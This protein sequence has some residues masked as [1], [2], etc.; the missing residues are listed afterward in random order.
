MELDT[1]GGRWFV[2]QQPDIA[3]A[4]GNV[5]DHAAVKG[6]HTFW[7]GQPLVIKV[8]NG[9]A[10]GW[11]R[12][13]IQARNVFGPLPDFYD[14]FNVTIADNRTGRALGGMNIEAS[15]R[16]YKDGSIY[17]YLEQGQNELLAVWTNDAYQE[18]VYDANIH[19]GKISLES[20]NYTPPQD[21]K[22]TAAEYCN[23]QGRFFWDDATG[24]ARTY[25]RDQTIAW[26]FNDLEPGIYEVTLS[27]RNYGSL[28]LPPGYNNFEVT[29]A[30]DGVS[31]K[32]LITAD[33]TNYNLG[34][35]ALDLRG[36]DI[37]VNAT[38]LND[39]YRESVY[40]ANI[41]IRDINLRKVGPSQRTG[42]A[43]YLGADNW[44]RTILLLSLLIAGGGLLVVFLYRR[45]TQTA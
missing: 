10:A 33:E 45:S 39:K 37:V 3:G 14:A 6:I 4:R 32:V 24:A 41:E 20:V 12:L 44:S 40:D 7:R 8:N 25:W 5:P 43:A 23:V 30:A 29:I 28:G 2:T 36:G 26:C 1:S 17:V 13:T 16:Q 27:A 31:E 19:I 38:W 21:L 11:V 9:C 34:I 15:D 35:V 18:D 22:K 42:L